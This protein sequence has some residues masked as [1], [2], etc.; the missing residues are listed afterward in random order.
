MNELKLGICQG[1]LTL[2]PNNELQ[3]FPQEKW[4]KE[5]EIAKSIGLNYIELLA[6]REHNPKNPIW[7]DVVM[8]PECHPAL[9]NLF[10]R[11]EKGGF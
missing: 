2:P 1:R 6:E 5:F 10:I 3:W 4:E 11:D 8:N 9:N 7:E